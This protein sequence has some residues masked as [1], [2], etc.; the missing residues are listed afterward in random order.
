MI[1]LRNLN[2][3]PLR[4]GCRNGHYTLVERLAE[5]ERVSKFVSK[6]FSEW[7]KPPISENQYEIGKAYVIT[8]DNQEKIGMCGSTRG[9]ISDGGLIDLWI[10]ID[11]GQRGK[12]YGERVV[13]Q[14]TEYFL[15]TIPKLNNITLVIN[16]D[17]K[18]SN[19]IAML[20]GYTLD[21]KQNGK[22]HYNYFG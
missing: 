15:D 5:D 13:V 1:K 16:K 20:S 17:N 9:N 21:K 6:R 14:M 4:I 22:N 7:V 18:T 3:E 12:G 2:L 10:A 19:K 11:E 8:N